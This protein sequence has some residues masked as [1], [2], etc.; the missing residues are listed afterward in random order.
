MIVYKIENLINGKIYVG[1]TKKSLEKRI[2]QH[3]HNKKSC[4]GKAIQEYGFENF[5]SEVIENCDSAEK[6]NEREKFWIKELNCKFPNGYNKSDGGE[7]IRKFS[8]KIKKIVQKRPENLSIRE[9]LNFEIGQRIRMTREAQK[10][11]R[12]Q[13]A[14]VAEISPQF[15]FDIESGKK[16][17]TSQTI[18]NL[19]KALN[20]STDYILLGAVTPLSKIVNNLEGLEPDKL[21]LA[22]EFIKVFSKGAMK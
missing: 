15:L 20:V 16:G 12:E 21:N 7:G 17:M 14:E 13:I 19:A 1:Q 18:I 2:E 8:L 22:E 4:I 9:T 10:K 6:L 3:K 11:T 5:H